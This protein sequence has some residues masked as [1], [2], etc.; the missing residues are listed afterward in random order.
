MEADL[1]SPG[2]RIWKVGFSGEP[3][4][5][6]VFWAIEDGEAWDL[7]LQAT[8]GARGNREEGR[9]IV[10]GNILKKSRETFIR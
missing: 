3:S 8:T 2:S 7:D 5:R 4:P 6:S 1:C 10:E 9:R